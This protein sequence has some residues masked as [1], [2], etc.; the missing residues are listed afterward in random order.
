MFLSWAL[1]HILYS[2]STHLSP[3]LL[4]NTNIPTLSRC[5]KD[6]IWDRMFHSPHNLIHFSNTDPFCVPCSA[7]IHLPKDAHTHTHSL[8]VITLAGPL[9]LTR[10]WR[11]TGPLQLFPRTRRVC[12]H[13][14]NGTGVCVNIIVNLQSCSFP[15]LMWARHCFLWCCFYWSRHSKSMIHT[16]TLTQV[17]GCYVMFRCSFIRK[18]YIWNGRPIILVGTHTTCRLSVQSFLLRSFYVEKWWHT[19]SI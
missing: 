5:V 1:K 8:S 2:E 13:G 18:K 11:S 14:R 9:L 4:S 6:G 16:R 19:P 3:L 15:T 7:F 12:V 17:K 10:P